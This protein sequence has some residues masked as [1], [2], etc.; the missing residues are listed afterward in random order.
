MINVIKKIKKVLKILI[1]FEKSKYIKLIKK[2]KKNSPLAKIPN[3]AISPSH[4]KF[5]L[6]IKT[7]KKK[8]YKNI[9]IVIEDT[10]EELYKF[11][12]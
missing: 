11:A 10:C 1:F 8:T 2:I 12:G 9:T 4:I 6:F 3:P 7:Y 5:L